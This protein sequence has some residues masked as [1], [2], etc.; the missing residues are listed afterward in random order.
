ML[1]KVKLLFDESK[2]DIKRLQKLVKQVNE[3]E[4]IFSQL[5]DEE[6]QEKT[7]EFKQ[8]LLDGATLNDIKIEAFAV[9]REASKRILGLRHYDVQ[10]MGGFVLYEGNIAEMQTGEGKTLVATLPSYLY[11]LEGKGVH[12]ITANEYL[13][14]RDY[15][16]MGK[17]F[18]FLG[19]KTGLNIS[20]MSPSEKKEAYKADI[21]YGTGTEFG[22]DYLRDHM[23][24]NIHD[25]VQRKLY[26]AII[27]EI[28]S[29]LIDEAR[30]P[31]I[32]ANK[33][34]I[35]TELFKVTSQIVKQFENGK[36]YEL[37][38]ETKQLFLTDEGASKIEAAFGIDNLYDAEHQPLL[39]NIMQSLRAAVIMQR[40][41]DYIVK[42]GKVFLVDQF[43]GRVM[44]GRTFSDGLHQAI[45]AKEGVEITEENDVQAMITIQ[46][47][48]RMYEKLCG[49]TGSATPA[50]TEFWET[51]NLHVITVP[52]NKPRKR[53]D[54]E[55][56]VYLTY[57][58]KAKKII[59]EIKKMNEIGRPVL[60]GTTSI[61][62]SEKLSQL[63][64]KEGI[65]HQVL[66]AKTEEDEARIIALAGQ[67]GQVMLAT[68]MAGRGT[69]ILLG[70]GV[71]ELGGLHIIGTERHESNRIDMQ[72][73]GRAGRQGDPGS[74]QF[75][76]SLEDELFKFYDQEELEKWKKKIKV[77]EEGLI[78][79]PDA[80][81]FVR[82][83]QETVEHAHYSARSHLLKLDSVIDQ[84]SKI[85]YSIRDQILMC[86]TSD[87]LLEATKYIESH[88]L[89]I[90]DKYCLEDTIQEE[91][92]IKGLCEEL[93]FIF[94]YF[95]NDVQN[96]LQKEKEQIKEIVMSQYGRLKENLL[97][98]KD[99][100]QLCIQ[101]RQLML[102]SIDS[103]WIRHLHTL[104]NAKEGVHLRAY[105]QED[106][107]R[108]FEMEAFHEFV[109]LK[110]SIDSTIAIHLVNY[111]KS[112]FDFEHVHE[113]RGDL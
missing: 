69:D 109:H 34:S 100:E 102:Q 85:I 36:D 50:K 45:E 8:R 64:R 79:Y 73:R 4:Y 9:V 24:Y 28:D 29:I 17:L 6:L 75:I 11:A 101:I 43:T 33:S 18:Q 38:P 82:K 42:D 90:I 23:V 39:H 106:P 70:E 57:E 103:L 60:I 111:I 12:I 14:R 112:M 71:A 68:N 32:I 74:S 113:K 40:D 87:I 47:Y 108:L 58:Q 93:S 67:R 20:N 49:M 15:E 27:D 21:T 56:L 80:S 54:M 65:K 41:V 98:L 22:F 110:H 7:E 97:T 35:A 48:F 51:Y 1:T 5:T 31:L 55:D 89:Q 61:A 53:I 25:K 26:Y 52:T 30:T 2:R 46:N 96:F 107:Y 92:N 19:L 99:E 95:D 37:Y 81:K 94:F 10:L 59:A 66:N 91:W 13:A 105:S 3:M 78:I 88:L 77:N 44:E 76:I 63:L 86:E 16:Q 62:Q 84:Q 83:V 104:N 72:L